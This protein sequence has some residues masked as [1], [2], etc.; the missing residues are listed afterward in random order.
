MEEDDDEVPAAATSADSASVAVHE[1]ASFG[2]GKHNAGVEKSVNVPPKRVK[3]FTGAL[4]RDDQG[5]LVNAES[6]KPVEFVVEGVKAADKFLSF[7]GPE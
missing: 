2:T 7:D 1:V 3:V 6:K 4:R 5:R